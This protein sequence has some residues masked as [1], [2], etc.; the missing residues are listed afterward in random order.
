RRRCMSVI[1]CS[2]D[3]LPSRPA[4][5]SSAAASPICGFMSWMVVWSLCLLGL[6][7]SFTSRGLGLGVGMSGVAGGGGGGLVVGG[8]GLR[9]G[10]CTGAGTWR[11]GA[12]MGF[13]SLWGARTNRSRF[14]ASAL[15]LGRSRQRCCGMKAYRRLLWWRDRIGWGL[16]SLSA[17]LFWRRGVMRMRL[18]CV[19]MLGRGFPATLCRQR[20][21]FWIIFRWRRTG[22][23]YAVWCLR[24]EGRA[25]LW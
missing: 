13:W 6:L 18:G 24:R 5:I 23:L 17:T 9:G 11:A 15:S 22:S 16:R 19:R 14:A 1:F 21:L 25:L 3:T 8:M 7:G 2:I 20:S 4:V 12:A 10:G